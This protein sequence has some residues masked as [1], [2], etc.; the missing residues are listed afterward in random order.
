[1]RQ[2]RNTKKF[3]FVL[4]YAL[5]LIIAFLLSNT[6][7]AQEKKTISGTVKDPDSNSVP[8][9]T[10]LVKG[11]SIVTITDTKGNYQF[12]IPTNSKILVF[13]FVGMKSLEKQ[14]GNST[15]IDVQLESS[16]TMLDE[17]VIIAYGT[18]KKRDMIGSVSKVKSSE[19]ALMPG[20]NFA[21]SIQGKAS[22]LQI[23]S[24]GI[25]GSAPQIKIRGISSI[26]SGT[27]PLWVVDGMVGGDAG[28]LNFHDIESVEVL[29]DA[30]ATAIY[31]SRGSNGVIIV[32]TK[33]G[34]KGDA[35]F[36]L[37]FNT[38]ISS[39]TKNNIGLGTTQNYFDI[40]DKGRA[41]R[42]MSI[43]DPQRDVIQ[44]FYTAWTTPITRD[45]ALASNPNYYDM[46]T[47]NGT[48]KDLNLS[49]NQGNDKSTTFASF[50]YRQ[51]KAS[52]IG[53]D[54]E[55]FN[56]RINN[57]YKKGI[58]SIGTQIT[59]NY[60]RSNN[61]DSWGSLSII[62]W[63]KAYDANDPSGYWNPRMNNADPGMNP[64]AK[65][66]SRYNLN[67]NDNF[68]IRANVFAEITVPGIKGLAVRGDGSF[69]YGIAQNSAWMSSV[70]KN[71]GAT[72][73]NSGSTSKNTNKSEQ[74]HFFT[75]YNNTFGD[76]SVD[77]VT[78]IEIN[79]GYT[80]Y[81]NVA[82][83]NLSG[84][85]QEEAT[86]GT[87]D[88]NN[89]A[90]LGNE[91]YTFG[92]FNRL[93]YKY[94]NRYLIGGSYIR[95]GS[96]RFVAS[97]RWGDFYSASIGWIISDESFMK[98]IKC[99]SLLKLRGS[100]GETGN[101]NIP[102]DA[103]ITSYSIK[104]KGYY[105]GDPNMYMWSVAN[106]DTR[107]EKTKSMDFGIDFGLFKNRINGSIAYYGKN[108][109]DMLLKVQ[110]PASAGIA[111]TGFSGFNNSIW[112]NI[113]SMYNQGLEFDLSV[114]VIKKSDFS[115]NSSFNITT[116]SNK[117]TSLDPSVDLKGTG[118]INTRP[119]VITKKGLAVGTYFL[120]EWAGVDTQK[121]IGL[122]YEIDLAKYKATGETVKTGNKI[123]ATVTNLNLHRIIQTG[124]TAMPST[125]VGWNNNIAYKSFDLSFSFY[126]SAGNYIYNRFKDGA[127]HVGDGRF[128]I[129]SEILT[130]SWQKAGDI[131]IYPELRWQDTYG[132]KS[133]GTV[134]TEGY[135]QTDSG[136]TLFLEK[137]DFVR[138]RDLTIGYTLPEIISSK[139]RLTGVRFYLS[140][141]NLLTL[142]KFSGW[143]PEIR[144]QD[145]KNGANSQG[146]VFDGSQFPQ[147]KTFSAGI[148]FNF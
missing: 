10:V 140:G 102:S 137:A 48:Y 77:A 35:S 54:I 147:T 16:V 36:N 1:M 9:V 82:G 88:G 104:P 7:Y 59:G 125:Y 107:W 74:Y 120:S 111:N 106:K 42:G 98:S 49:I 101:Q 91:G 23:V 38:G 57:D 90:V 95:E 33:K 70:I 122:I 34:K 148:T 93:D 85:F 2:G 28:S 103:S 55:Q 86:I 30:S 46:I 97:N 135:G 39:L 117:V 5:F 87:M 130:N 8:G 143:D 73:G 37:T 75:K 115:W 11:T 27:D 65:L 110:L 53:R 22:G 61:Q 123:P 145:N 134:G 6:L 3:S 13:S 43:L 129:M 29:K 60:S 109:N 44:P 18:K 15:V 51:D 64:M 116:N 96:S 79:R 81:S 105:N 68:N 12:S 19:L 47:R 112:A 80:L 45:E 50:N 94:K 31:G 119:G 144:M 4:M 26:S 78:G 126:L 76:H 56:G 138:L 20:G 124:K 40:L 52:L 14:I 100:Y 114:N 83:R 92:F 128:N 142:T 62:P 108:V 113:G 63:V 24:D 84:A 41:N 58:F 32:T 139:L 67:K 141:S 132:Y 69:A 136:S 66:D 133:D 21:T 131:A 118:I 99:I 71:T 127:T 17:T 25:P 72:S 121:G 146:I 89:R